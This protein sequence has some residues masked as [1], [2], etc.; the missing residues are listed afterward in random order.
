MGK[1]GLNLIKR[2]L[3]RQQISIS[4]SL[5]MVELLENVDILINRLEM[6]YPVGFINSKV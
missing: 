6:F 1:E 5:E 3:I 2:T 4:A